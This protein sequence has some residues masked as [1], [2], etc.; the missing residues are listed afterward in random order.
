[1]TRSSGHLQTPEGVG[2]FDHAAWA[3]ST[4]RERAEAACAW[5]ADGLRCGQRALYVAE[6][7]VDELTSELSS[8]PGV[9]QA[10][11][12]GALVVIPSTELYDLSA[13]IDAK[14]QL[15]VYAGA[16][17]QAIADG[18][19]GMR[20]AAD[21]TP[22]VFDAARRTSH[23]HWE[24]VADRYMTDYPLAPICMY[25]T[26]RIK[27]VRAIAC[28]HPLQGPH[29]QP[30]ALYGASQKESVLIGE[31]DAFSAEVL[32]E[33]LREA[34]ETDEV[35]D[36]SRLSFVDARAA[37]TLH[38]EIARRRSR[39]RQLTLLGATRVFRHVWAV[40][41]FDESALQAA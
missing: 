6:G 10:I 39:G 17:D 28:A 7:S 18:F 31:V 8:V 4:D 40:C 38:D 21:I 16:V 34:P 3:Y 22:L 30:F 13:L 36:V 27:D 37:W 1:M 5:I 2:P 23:L 15:A 35:I 20:V 11:A 25:D 9:T 12:S 24:Q 19:G 14:A 33:V 29:R 41:G 32:A 26:R